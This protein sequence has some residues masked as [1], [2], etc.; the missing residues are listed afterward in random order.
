MPY[1]VEPTVEGVRIIFSPK[2]FSWRTL[3][4][5]ALVAALWVAYFSNHS[6]Q[7]YGLIWPGVFL[8]IFVASLPKKEIINVDHGYLSRRVT[9]LGLGWTTRY[10]LADV[11][12]PHY[13]PESGVGRNKKPS[14]LEFG[15]NGETK[16]MLPTVEA[17]EVEGI[18]TEI[19]QRFPELAT[20]WE[21][22]Q[23]LCGS[24]GFLSLNI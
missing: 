19:V 16:R 12:N 9:L 7:W 15:Y 23:Q 20:R 2:R 18:L 6:R 17:T 11:V 1:A 4:P 3:L 8:V 22:R 10:K 14:F 21:T 24:G 13:E 5:G